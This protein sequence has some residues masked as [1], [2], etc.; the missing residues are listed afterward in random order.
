MFP[1]ASTEVW[2]AFEWQGVIA[3][4]IA[5]ADTP[6]SAVLPK[7]LPARHHAHCAPHPT[8]GPYGTVSSSQARGCAPGRFVHDIR[9]SH[10]SSPTGGKNRGNFRLTG[11]SANGIDRSLSHA[12]VALELH[13]PTVVALQHRSCPASF[14]LSRERDRLKVSKTPMR[15]CNR[16]AGEKSSASHSPGRPV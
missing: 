16:L 14:L 3:N 2:S 7:N 12:A 4:L 1:S 8:C 5:Q 10:S 13:T 9:D 6:L 15:G 11:R